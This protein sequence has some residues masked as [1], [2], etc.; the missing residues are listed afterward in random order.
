MAKER[1]SNDQIVGILKAAAETVGEPLSVGKYDK[2][3]TQLGGPS[4]IRLIQR[5]GSWAAA[6]QEADVEPGKARRS[7]VRKW[8]RD[9]IVE[10][11]RT[12]LHQAKKVSFADFSLWLSRVPDAPSGATCRNVGG[13]WSSILESARAKPTT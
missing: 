9:Q 7:Y 10:L 3:R 6:C 13:S 11:A 1:Y 4:A 8:E 5:F 2:V 12:Y